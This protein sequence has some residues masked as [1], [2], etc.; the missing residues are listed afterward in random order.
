M[1]EAIAVQRSW[2]LRKPQAA[3][4]GPLSVSAAL[5][6]AHVKRRSRPDRRHQPSRRW[7]KG[8]CEFLGPEAPERLM[9]AGSHFATS[10]LVQAIP[11]ACPPVE[12]TQVA[13]PAG[14]H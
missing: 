11:S 7:E 9:C 2:L 8:S 10:A 6:H 5:T 4:T 1:F 12:A 13:L 14:V 3:G